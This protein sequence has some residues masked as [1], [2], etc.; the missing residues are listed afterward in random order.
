M[1][2][3]GLEIFIGTNNKN[4]FA[5]F[6]DALKNFGIKAKM[7]PMKLEIEETGVTYR[8]NALIKARA[9]SYT[10]LS[11]K[12]LDKYTLTQ[13]LSKK[14]LQRFIIKV[15]K[16]NELLEITDFIFNFTNLYGSKFKRVG[17][18]NRK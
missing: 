4:N 9:V 13:T 7:Q 5:E 15:R 1:K 12:V 10:H 14:I 8:E 6:E 17:Y 2:L 11:P 16:P 3:E 18:K